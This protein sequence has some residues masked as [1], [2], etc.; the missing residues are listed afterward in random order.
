MIE[1][2]ILVDCRRNDKVDHSVLRPSDQHQYRVIVQYKKP[3][4]IPYFFII[5]SVLA[6]SNPLVLPLFYPAPVA[7]L[8]KPSR[9]LSR[10]R[11]G[12]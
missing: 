2:K 8:M 6:E 12:G 11:E 9:Q 4:I 10:Q 1:K 5:S 3:V 7:N